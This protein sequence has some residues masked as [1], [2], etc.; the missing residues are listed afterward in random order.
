MLMI[1]LQRVGRKHEPVFRLVLTDSKNGPKSGKFLEILG[2]FDARK[3][4]KAEFK[5]DAIMGWMSKGAKMSDTVHN[6]F[7]ERK[8]IKGKK[9]NNLPKK[10]PVI[11][12][13]AKAAKEAA[14][15]AASEPKVETEVE[16]TPESEVALEPEQAPVEPEVSTPEVVEEKTV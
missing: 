3:S 8:L 1:R 12:E 2:N 10:S 16:A 9:I 14:E 11:S 13:E 7:V 15:K 5:V 6:L 4:E